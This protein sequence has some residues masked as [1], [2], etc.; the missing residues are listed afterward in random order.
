M[1]RKLAIIFLLITVVI[2]AMGI[3]LIMPVTPDLIRELLDA[4]LSEAA[5][6]GGVLSASFAVMQFLFGAVIG[7][8]SDRY[9]RRP[10]L[11]ASL[12]V[13]AV[14]Y[15]V[16]GVTHSIWILLI[17]RLIGGVVSATQ[18]TAAA[19]MADI[20]KPE[21]KAANFGLLGAAF[22]IGFIIGP[23]LGGLLG[24]FGSRTPFFAAAAL[25]F[26]NLI[27]GYFILP[28]TV[29]DKI[30][31]PLE[32]RRMNPFR[33]LRYV[34]N[35]PGV[36]P[37]LAMFFFYQLAFFVYPSVWAY[38]TQ[39][40]FGWTPWDVGLSL[41]AYGIGIAVVQG[42]LIRLVVP[43][44]GEW[45]TV[46]VGMSISIA[47]FLS[48]GF[49]SVGWMIYVLIPFSALG[50]IAQP[51]LQGIMSKAVTDD[52][53]GELQG[54][55]TGVGAIASIISPLMMTGAFGYF[56]RASTAIYAPSA[57]FYLAAVL[58]GVALVIF[59]GAWRRITRPK[60]GLKS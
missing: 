21:E 3:G 37:L 10:V 56:T 20:S 41:A 4:D 24:E 35:L 27:F 14:D 12:M 51:A 47:A 11:L 52:A 18:S 57:P 49:I 55:L 48:F 50:M 13:M 32:W 31:R 39:E 9:G 28:E 36:G 40:K 60:A 43:K 8:L 58:D 22:G 6:W 53:Q 34:G 33:A 15:L 45:R 1:P 23:M 54:V 26:C 2:D 19:Y 44:L 29:T 5:L 38:Y 59:I 16:M 17:G 25:A 7:N 46:M 30:R 42:G